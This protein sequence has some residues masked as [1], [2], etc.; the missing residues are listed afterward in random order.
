[1][2]EIDYGDASKYANDA[3]IEMAWATKA[4]ER[5]NVHMNLL[6]CCDTRALRLN[7]LQD[8]IHT[9]FRN[10]FPDLDV[11][12]VTE[13]ELKHDGM[14]E[15]WHEFCEHFK[16]VCFSCHIFFCITAVFIICEIKFI[17]MKHDSKPT[18]FSEV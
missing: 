6:M 9:S 2:D 1:M 11:H 18:A 3:A 10:S 7:K 5:A 4:A 17:N 15:K 12:K 8:V 13:V 14:K 16:E